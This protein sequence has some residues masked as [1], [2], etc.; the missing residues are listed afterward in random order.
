MQ[1]TTSSPMVGMCN[2]TTSVN[3]VPALVTNFFQNARGQ[4]AQSAFSAAPAAATVTTPIGDQYLNKKS[5]ST[6]AINWSQITGSTTTAFTGYAAQ[7]GGTFYGYQ[8]GPGYWGKTFFIW[9][10]DPAAANDW[11][12]KFFENPNGTVCNDDTALYDSSGNWLSPSGNYI[13]NYKAILNWIANTGPNP[14][15]PV[16]RAGNILYYSSIPTDVPSSATPGPTR[17]RQSRTPPR[18]SGRSTSISCSASGRIR[19]GTCRPRGTRHA[20]M[21]RISPAAAARRGRMSRS[22]GRITPLPAAHGSIRPITRCVRGTG[23]GS[24]RPR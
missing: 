21:G 5:S 16:L 17:T 23:S 13:I 1:C 3:G 24:G 9:P 12:K 10:P 11:R 7:Q 6:C 18:G 2:V 20:A 14:F 4:S 15:P 22:P 8:Q 19:S